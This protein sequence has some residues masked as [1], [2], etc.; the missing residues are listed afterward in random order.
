MNG[1]DNASD[2]DNNG[3]VVRRTALAAMEMNGSEG[4]FIRHNKYIRVTLRSIG[5]GNGSHRG[6]HTQR[7]PAKS[8][9]RTTF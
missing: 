8:I 5:K 4:L 9:S 7:A 1:Y 3:P 2:V 6:K